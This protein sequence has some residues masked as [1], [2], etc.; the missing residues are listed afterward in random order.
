MSIIAKIN[1]CYCQVFPYINFLIKLVSI[2][3]K[4][5]RH[6]NKGIAQHSHITEQ[7]T[8]TMK[9]LLNFIFPYFLASFFTTSP[10]I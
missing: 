2:I 3:L 7:R 8:K 5:T 6:I 1:N 4:F 10:I 9:K